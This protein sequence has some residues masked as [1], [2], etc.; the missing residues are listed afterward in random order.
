M[1][2]VG[3]DFSRLRSQR[4][5]IVRI[6]KLEVLNCKKS[7]IAGAEL[8]KFWVQGLFWT[9][10]KLW[11]LLFNF[12]TVQGLII[13]FSETSRADCKFLKHK[14]LIFKKCSNWGLQTFEVRASNFIYNTSCY[15]VIS[16]C[17]SNR[18][19]GWV[20]TWIGF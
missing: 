20:N 7:G 14:G 19:F 4:D 8:S 5:W 17:I 16:W 10:L 2:S 6:K 13:K 18:R 3:D 12:L 1:Q 15:L 11:G 9:Y